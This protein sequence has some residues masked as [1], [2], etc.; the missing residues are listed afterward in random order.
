MSPRKKK[1]PAKDKAKEETSVEEEAPAEPVEE[2][3]PAE[4]LE[5]ESEAGSEDKPEPEPE[6]EEAPEPDVEP[7]PDSAEPEAEPEA[8]A[9][10]EGTPSVDKSEPEEAP[11]SASDVLATQILNLESSLTEQVNKLEVDEK[12]KETCEQMRLG[13]IK[14]LRDCRATV[15]EARAVLNEMREQEGVISKQL[16]GLEEARVYINEK[17]ATFRTERDA[18]LRLRELNE[19]EFQRL[20]DGV[21]NSEEV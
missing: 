17:S 7:E 20:L 15:E 19:G 18:Y 5:S 12:G 6:A 13:A 1:A 16:Q 14:H 21:R 9:E 11:P 4:E 8:P 2:E 10:P 3:A